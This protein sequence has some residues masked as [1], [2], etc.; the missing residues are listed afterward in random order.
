MSDN[1]VY[2]EPDTNKEYEITNFDDGN[3]N[4]S[5]YTNK[6]YIIG[7]WKGKIA[8]VNVDDLRI[9]IASISNWKA[10]LL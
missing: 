4:Y 8:L 2:F 5:E 6:W 10:I 9:R 3:S 7:K 1:W